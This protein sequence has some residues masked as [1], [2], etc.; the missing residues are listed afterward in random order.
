MPRSRQ[1]AIASASPALYAA[2]PPASNRAPFATGLN[3]QSV[4]PHFLAQLLQLHFQPFLVSLELLPLQ[5]RL[6]LKLLGLLAHFLLLPAE[7]LAKLPDGCARIFGG[8]FHLGLQLSDFLLQFAQFD[9]RLGVDHRTV[10]AFLFLQQF[11][12]LLAIRKREIQV[13]LLLIA[14]YPH[15]DGPAIARLHRVREIARV[16]H[17]LVVNLDD[18]VSGTEAS[19]LR[20]AAFLDR[21]HQNTIAILHAEEFSQLWSD[22]LHRQSAP[23]R[24]SDH[25]H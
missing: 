14:D 1:D 2:P 20:A 13:L 19:L 3:I 18:H 10:K 17:R 12:R 15:T 11:A 7:F 8:Q 24:G 23:R 22:V 4:C 21:A 25:H 16:V 6:V 9:R 5:L